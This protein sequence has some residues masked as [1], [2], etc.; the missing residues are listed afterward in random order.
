M[1]RIVDIAASLAVLTTL[2]P[3]LILVGVAVMVESRGGP[4][5]LAPRVGRG[6]RPFRMWKFRTMRQRSGEQGPAITSKGDPRVTR[7]GRLLRGTKIDEL[8]QFVK[9]LLGDMTI[10]GPRPEAPEF[11]KLYDENQMEILGYLPGVTGPV[12]L[13][14]FNESD[15]I[16]PGATG[17]REYASRIMGAKIQADLKYLQSRSAATDARIVGATVARVART[18]LQP[19]SK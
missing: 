10:V 13:M 5:Y 1:R 11:V 2:A 15:S 9:V 12:Q 7:L 8:P 14:S 17:E 16:E 3:L 19:N 4:F 18:I 6:G